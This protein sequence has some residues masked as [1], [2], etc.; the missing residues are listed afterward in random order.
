M[1]MGVGVGVGVM[2][3][4]VDWVMGGKDMG[5]EDWKLILEMVMF[6]IFLR[7]KWVN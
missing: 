5:L 7:F 3:V 1:G 2:G 6:W 4:G